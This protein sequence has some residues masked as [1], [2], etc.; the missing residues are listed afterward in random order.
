MAIMAFD[1]ST[2]CTGWGYLKD[3]FTL[4]AYGEIKPKS[5]D[6]DERFKEQYESLKILLDEYKID[7]VICED[8]YQGSNAATSKKLIRVSTMMEVLCMERGIPFEYRMPSAWR[9][10]LHGKGSTDKVLTWN[11]VTEKFDL[12]LRKGQTDITDAIGIGLS[13]FAGKGV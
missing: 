12:K 5:K 1:P 10:R 2:V 8:Q 3:E 13:E 9:K 11:Y 7:K 4:L 6:V